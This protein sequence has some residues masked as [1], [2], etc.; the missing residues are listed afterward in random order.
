MRPGITGWAVLHGRNSIAYT[1]RIEL[2]NWYIDHW[3]IGLDLRI[4]LMTV[5]VVLRSEGLKL[6]QMAKDIDDLR[7][8]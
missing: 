7:P 3:S 5:P 1:R 8:C 4:L 2:D 6:D